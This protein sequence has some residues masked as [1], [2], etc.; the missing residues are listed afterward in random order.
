MKIILCDANIVFPIFARIIQEKE[1]THSD[2]FLLAKNH[3][4]YISTTIL[5]EIDENLEEKLSITLTKEHI[6]TFLL[7][8]NIKVCDSREFDRKLIIYV[9]DMDDA[10]ILQDAIDIHAEY[11]ISRNLKDFNIRK[12]NEDFDLKVM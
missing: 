5:A 11:L 7:I 8:S 3:E 2:V 10:Q 12:I 4:V 1:I 6:E 9:N